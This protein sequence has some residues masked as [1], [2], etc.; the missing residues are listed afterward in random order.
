MPTS[1][2]NPDELAARL[3][4]RLGG[5]TPALADRMMANAK[6]LAPV[7]PAPGSYVLED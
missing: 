4:P 2:T 5:A 7:G 1:T 6:G 3:Q